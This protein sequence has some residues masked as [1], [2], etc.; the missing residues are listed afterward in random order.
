MLHTHSHTHTLTHNLDRVA[1]DKLVH[2]VRTMFSTGELPEQ[3][4]WGLLVLV[5]KANG[6]VLVHLVCTMF[7]TSELPEQLSWG[8]LV[9]VP[10]AKGGV[11]GIGLLEV[12]WKLCSSIVDACLKAGIKFHDSLHGFRSC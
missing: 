8:L 5:P 11:H 1:W 4:S 6:G 12:I 7:L 10:K 2:L 3:L 9:L